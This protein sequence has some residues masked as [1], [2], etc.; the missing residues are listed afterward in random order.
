MPDEIRKL[1][2]FPEFFGNFL[3]ERMQAQWRKE[4]ARCIQDME[5][6]NDADDSCIDSAV[7]LIALARE[8]HR[9]FDN[10]PAGEKRRLLNFLLSNCTRANR[11]LTATF[12]EPF[13]FLEKTVAKMAAPSAPE[14]AESGQKTKW[15]PE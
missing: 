3:A 7:A 8:A 9:V 15:L 12:A 13:D 11:E 2:G 14:G 5:R 6:H 10:Q 1:S 4:R